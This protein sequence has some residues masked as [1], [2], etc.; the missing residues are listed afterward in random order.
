MRR[1][2]SLT[3]VATLARPSVSRGVCSFNRAG[4]AV[5]VSKPHSAA[6]QRARVCFSG[7]TQ[8]YSTSLAD[9]A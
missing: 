8:T 9:F 7:D 5:G 4:I 1:A 3:E 6:L 2:K